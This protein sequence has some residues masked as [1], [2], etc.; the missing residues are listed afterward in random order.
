MKFGKYLFD[1]FIEIVFVL[2]GYIIILMMLFAFK[3]PSEAIIGIT[4]VFAI[5]CIAVILTGYLKRIRFYNHLINNVD[6]LYKKY[7]VLEMLNKQSF[8]D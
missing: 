4:I 7:L 3:V 5:I 2:F 6:K 8:Y 1:K